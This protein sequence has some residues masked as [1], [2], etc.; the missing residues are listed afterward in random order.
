LASNGEIGEPCGV[1]ET[2]AV[3]EPCSSTPALSHPRISFSIV[4]SET[5]RA[6]SAIRVL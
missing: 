1:P 4:P 3:T 2:V 5:L 6:T